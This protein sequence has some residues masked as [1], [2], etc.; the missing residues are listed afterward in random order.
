MWL[1]VMSNTVALQGPENRAG[2]RT[3]HKDRDAFQS[4]FS[5]KHNGCF[6]SSGNPQDLVFS[7]PKS[8]QTDVERRT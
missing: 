8:L 5:F 4:C 1:E 2:E 7:G 3:L 6:A